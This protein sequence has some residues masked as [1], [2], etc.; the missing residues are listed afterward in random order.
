MLFRLA[1]TL[2]VTAQ[3]PYDLGGGNGKVIYIGECSETR[4]AGRWQS[5]ECVYPTD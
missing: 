1:H 5:G 3:L 4:L 2:C